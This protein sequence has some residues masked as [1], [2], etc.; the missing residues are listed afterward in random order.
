MLSRDNMK[1]VIQS[2]SRI[3]GGN[4]KWLLLA[5]SGLA[6][7]GH[8]VLISCKPGSP[9][10]S[11]ARDAGLRTTRR[12]LGG[13]A[14]LFHVLGFMAMLR[15]ERPDVLLLTAF[16]R[17]FWGGFAAR[18]AGVPRI[19]ERMGIERVLPGKWKYRHA[20]R[21]YIDGM[22]VNSA[23]IRDRWLESA[24][25]YPAHE[26]HVVLNGVGRP[27][28]AGADVREELGIDTDR[29]I[30]AAAGRLESRKGFDVLLNAFARSG[31]TDAQLIIAGTGEDEAA[32]RAQ[33]A[34]LGIADR[35][36]WLGFRTDMD[37][38]LTSADIFVLPSRLEG[39][40]NVML[41]AMAAGCLVV[42]TDI[43]GVR[44][45]IGVTRD[46]TNP[47]GWI[48]P[49]DDVAA[50]AAAIDAAMQVM[51]E[52]GTALER[53]RAELEF[54]VATWFSIDAMVTATERALIGRA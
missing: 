47:A 39:M 31:A 13:D 33:S 2:D 40:A 7:R 42:A 38:V 25:W 52:D 48:V 51:A 19:V 10:E 32:L 20:F 35:V 17:S 23:V 34:A 3:W 37:A 18:R 12:H 11:R 41:E 1:L 36:R 54:R 24:P 46:R 27:A 53:M 4:E 5:G 44:E 50:M 6:A 43:S 14:D 8:D 26:V 49:V 30:I 28:T 21:R 16:K 29:R 45:A 22:I 9:V 15:A